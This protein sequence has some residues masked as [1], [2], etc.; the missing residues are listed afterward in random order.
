MNILIG[1]IIQESNTFSP[2]R[3]TMEDFRRHHW[4]AGVAVR[5]LQVENE[6][7]GFMDTAEAE[8]VRTVPVV[9]ANAVS[10]G[11][12]TA[13][14]FAELKASLQSLLQEALERSGEAVDGAYFALH[15][16]MVA[17]GCDDTEAELAAMIRQAVGPD[18]PFLVSL[19][20]HA[21]VTRE[22]VRQVDGIVGFRTYP[23]TDFAETG[24]RSA[25]L[26]FAAVRGEVK[27]YTVLRKLPLVVPAENSQSSHGPF[28]E[29]WG[30]AEAG[31][32]RGD[33]L[34]TSLFPVQ[35]WLDI[36][37]MGSAV[38][39]VG[40]ARKGEAAVREAERLADA[41]W[42]RRESFGIDLYSVEA[43]IAKLRQGEPGRGPFV[44]SDSADSPSA[45]SIGDS[46]AVLRGLIDAGLHRTHRCLLT[47]VDAEAVDQ[48]IAAGV[49]QDLSLR[50]GYAFTPGNP[51]PLGEPM[52]VQG[53]VRRI[54]DGRFRMSGGYAKG[55]EAF[56]GRCV[57]FEVGLLS[58]L[59]TERATFSGDPAMYRSMGLEPSEADLVMVKSANQFRADYGSLSDRIYI[60]DT[61]GY[62]SA[63]LKRLPFR[64]LA[65][66]FYPIDEPLNWRTHPVYGVDRQQREDPQA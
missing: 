12:M 65:R 7:R 59:L 2:I 22:L 27:P 61:P 24:R 48:A 6:L 55:T 10:S 3:S 38:V 42:A 5:S 17:E 30:E 45:G 64:K 26:L 47:V 18:V 33:S 44:V 14:A 34:A 35:P 37:E 56:M 8:G 51:Q 46:N 58:V 20:L 41:F 40:D 66:P 62:S 9:S 21:N 49:E 63:N 32:A 25:E 52:E 4:L 1:S 60:L 57:V 53:K 16:A 19:D 54:G 29:L 28:A 36:D 50:V 23:H 11:I 31:E 13:E 39:V 43:I 15:G